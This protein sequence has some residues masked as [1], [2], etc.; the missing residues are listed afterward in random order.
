M[1][2]LHDRRSGIDL[3]RFI[4]CL[5]I[6]IWHYQ[7]FGFVAPG[8][9]QFDRGAQP[10]HS[11]LALLYDYQHYRVELFWIISGF[12]FYLMLGPALAAKRISARKF[13]T[14]RLA[15]LYPLH[16][17]SF[18]LVAVLQAMYWRQNGYYFV[19]QANDLPHALLHL[20]MASNWGPTI[21]QSFNGPVWSLSA[22]IPCYGLFFVL[23]RRFG[24]SLVVAL[25]T[26]LVALVAHQFADPVRPIYCAI[27]FFCGGAGAIVFLRC[28][29]TPKFGPLLALSG[30]IVLATI[31]A[32]AVLGLD[33]L[34]P[35][36]SIIIALAGPAMT[37]L[38]A[39][40]TRFPA[41]L[42]RLF[43]YLGNISFGVYLM[44]FPVQLV[45]VQIY[46]ANGWRTDTASYNLF[47]AFFGFSLLAAMAVQR[48]IEEPGNRLVRQM[49]APRSTAKA[50]A[51]G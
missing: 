19:Y 37:I 14:D 46:A 33:W 35:K 1:T 30:A 25:G 45:L 6:A 28:A 12:V 13:V 17:A 27:Y 23:V 34:M 16:I 26:A 18:A 15:R 42:A 21:T 36:I 7:H 51:Q 40:L 22:L 49:L 8:D 41:G 48:F 31:G 44:H 32:G 3:L 47:F 2:V 50:A 38:I 39:S 24:L 20:F 11:V 43:Q 4:S 5:G 9:W 10:F 29:G